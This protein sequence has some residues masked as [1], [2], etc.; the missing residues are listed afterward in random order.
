MILRATILVLAVALIVLSLGDLLLDWPSLPS[1]A[2]VPL[3]ILLA[4]LSLLSERRR[5]RPPRRGER[6]Q[7]E[8]RT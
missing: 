8:R 1:K 2:T 7:S 5:F 3:L 6:K 4:G